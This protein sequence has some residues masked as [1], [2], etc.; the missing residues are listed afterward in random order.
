[1]ENYKGQVWVYR[2]N[3]S[4]NSVFVKAEIIDKV[5]SADND[6]EHYKVKL[7]QSDEL[8]TVP[9]KDIQKANPA[10]FDGDEDMASLTHLNEPSVLNNL[11]LRYYEDKIYTHSG[12]FLVTV[13]P[14]K[15]INIY[16]R[17]FIE[18]YSTASTNEDLKKL[19]PHIFGTAQKAFDNLIVE[20]KDQS[21]LVTGESGAGKTE[22]TKKVIQHI[23]AISTNQNNKD[24]A[25][26]LEDQILQANP[27]L[28][29]FGNATTVRNLNSSRFGKFVKIKINS[30][31]QE[32]S[33][34][35]IDWYLLEK[36]RVIRQDS[37]ERNYHVFYQLLKGAPDAMLK[38][39]ML[40]NAT[41]NDFEYLKHGLTTSVDNINDK[42]EFANLLKAFNVMKFDETSMMNVFKILSVI[43][44]LG[45]ITF[46]NSLQDTKQAVL[47][48]D[49]DKTIEIVSTLLGVT[50]Q[51][52]RK[53]FLNSK[54]RVGRDVVSQQRTA[55]QAKFSIDALSKSLYEKLFQYLVDKINENFQNDT[56]RNEFLDEDTND[57]YIG[58]LDIAGFEIFQK[59]SFEQL[60][61]NYT[62]EK[63]QQ[64]FNHH[65]FVLEQ[66]EYM[67]EGISW[68][69]IDFGNEL[70]PTI[71][72]IEGSAANKR[73]TNIFSILDEECV[74]PK[75]SDK[76]FIDK[77]F[78]ELEPKD[79]KKMDQS[80]LIFKA[81]RIRDGFV[82]KHYAGS[83]DY[84]VDGWL[85][86]NKDPLSSTMIELLSNSKDIFISDF[87]LSSADEFNLTDSPV[88]GS[89]RKKSGMFR[90][91]AQRHKEQLT[92]LMDNLGKTYPHFVRCILP[93]SEKKAGV[94]NDEVVLHQLRCNGVLEGIRIARSGY[95]NRI[96]FKTFASHY[97]ILSNTFY[98]SNKS[99]DD[100]SSNKQ[101]CELILD[102]LDLD[103]EVCK[104]GLTKLFFRNGVLAGLEKKRDEKLAAV[105]TGFNAIAR[106]TLIRRD[107]KTKLQRLRASK[108][109]I[110]NFKMYS[111]YN[112]DP[113]FKLVKALKPRLDDTAILEVQ[114]KSQIAKLQNKVQ[115]LNEQ[116]SGELADRS[117][118]AAKIETLETE[119]KCSQ[120][121]ISKKDAE[122]GESRKSIVQLEKQLAELTE[123][124]TNTKKILDEKEKELGR[125]A[126]VNAEDAEKL[127]FENK[128]LAD[129]KKKIEVKLQS[130]IKLHAHVK[131]DLAD[132]KSTID[133]KDIELSSLKREKRTR[134]AKTNETVDDL[135]H[136]L[137]QAL[138]EVKKLKSD[139]QTKTKL[140]DENV[141]SLSD[142]KSKYAS[143]TKDLSELKQIAVKYEES[144]ARFEEQEKVRA[145]FK[146]YKLDYK[147]LEQDY[148]QVK[149]LLK[150]KVNDEITFKTGRQ[151]FIKELEETK[152]IIRDLTQQLEVEKSAVVKLELKLKDAE[153]ETKN[154]INSKK[155]LE[156]D[157]SQLLMRL[158][159]T[160]PEQA[161]INQYQINEQKRALTPETHELREEVRLLRT[162]LAAE[163]YENR[164]LK[165]IIKKGCNA[166]ELI[167][168]FNISGMGS[169]DPDNGENIKIFNDHSEVEELRLKLLMEKEAFQ[170][171]QKH[172]L[173][174]QK[175]S[176]Y[177]NRDS[178]EFSN[179]DLLDSDAIE[180]KSKY[181]MSQIEVSNLKEQLKELRLQRE[182]IALAKA[183][184]STKGVLADSTNIEN[185][186]SA[187]CKIVDEDEGSVK[188]KH[189]N[190]RL[191]SAINE[192]KTKLNRLQQG[193]SGRFEQEEMIIQLRND[194][195]SIMLKN[196][197][198]NSS[199]GLYKDRSED[200][201]SK[202]S[203]AE[204]ELL[205]LTR[206]RT[207]M[208][209]EISH[210]KEKVKRSQYQYEENEAQV[211]QLTEK[212]RGL[213]KQLLDKQFE[214]TRLN[215]QHVLLMEKYESS[216]ELRRSIKSVSYKHQ[217]AE[218]QRL[219]EELT[220][221]LNK[222]TEL[223]KMLRS[224]NSQLEDSRKELMGGKS[225]TA[226]VEKDN[227]AL[228]I[229][230]NKCMAKNDGL[231]GEVRENMT[232]SRSLD[233]QVQ[234]LK[235]ANMDLVKE[236]DTLVHSK[237]A[238]EDKLS[239]ISIQL[240]HL[241][242]KAREDANN[243]ILAQQL[244]EKLED[245][246]AQLGRVNTS[247]SELRAQ[248]SHITSE[249]HSMEEKYWKTFEENKELA[250][251]NS[252]L[253]CKIEEMSNRFK[254]EIEAHESHW[255]NRVSELDQSISA[256]RSSQINE[257][258]EVDHL[259][260]TIKEWESRYNDLVRMKKYS[261]EEIKNL[262]GRIE[263]LQQSYESLSVR[264]GETQRRCR[265]L[266]KEC[267]KFR[268]IATLNK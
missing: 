15:K 51:E 231:L 168:R 59:N 189:D 122:V 172:F 127:R 223:N 240:D 248:Y 50:A 165:A 228:K 188:L 126:T 112:Q 91:V 200:Y 142:L 100:N 37:Q 185:N 213:E 204:D 38:K 145:K 202:L 247:L 21:I 191:N 95:P 136:K 123:S 63:L 225:S 133:A 215:E 154:A 212:I 236:R 170:R 203:K 264:E 89:P 216:E 163:S 77:L 12:L 85:D 180:Y 10:R 2:P 146:H 261:D 35:H 73:Q 49:A 199:V 250:K 34:A 221:S 241:S 26:L 120:E 244:K 138:V 178:S 55:T 65:M 90:T 143:D 71:E 177:N 54:I 31:K 132:L 83:V 82:I 60:C 7:L 207:K 160:N 128:E 4:E 153:V 173:E 41:L 219:G 266:M 80:K 218:I 268:D 159:A 36:S 131:K 118:V 9:L 114:Y 33:G 224:R 74:V 260:S 28:E 194:M 252:E 147:R 196:T 234:V 249:L 52:F 226:K 101:L 193:N 139:L 11:K 152:V 94:F 242:I 19:P 106:G 43:L 217:E 108:V 197:A 137:S 47:S 61:I 48:E 149:S 96:D 72:I 40:F 214:I 164:N 171:L 27:I 103:P 255:S 256:Q 208:Q 79:A 105:F 245:S 198:L 158:N 84:S 97:G 102:G 209:D 238:L 176:K 263:K 227:S 211:T 155:K 181:Q 246:E 1:M 144:K 39:L 104:I 237:R 229:A 99:K 169:P 109:L 254:A 124:A 206:E 182:G 174:L 205:S 62:N 111:K 157:N 210:L 148:A 24:N 68:K 69:Y 179:M 183:Q 251:L 87:F 166:G 45:N 13:N 115:D 88:K 141:S 186:I 110:N 150:Q 262:E 30:K 190:L 156:M 259:N 6:E 17:D 58:I 116:M 119:I 86:K 93:N 222:E 257:R 67:K 253:Y 29:S 113:W 70:K 243:A 23:L 3:P 78:N 140:L 239:E 66:S 167:D 117:A 64:F 134:E 125:L 220:K 230:L 135:Q 129:A 8:V 184:N 18:L 76:S 265:Q 192:L 258:F 53:S 187:T 92:M 130:E 46:K 267:E 57:H 20:N 121:I 75:G 162:R 14:Y 201:Y 44:H 161:N 16:N 107:F 25:L 232:K 5:T 175:T 81:N 195:K 42:E 233:Q 22:N 32:L 98:D 56:D 151:Q 235:V